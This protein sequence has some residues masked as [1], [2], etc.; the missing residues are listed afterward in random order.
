M[1]DNTVEMA[2]GEKKLVI[3]YLKYVILICFV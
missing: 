2:I 3:D 1:P